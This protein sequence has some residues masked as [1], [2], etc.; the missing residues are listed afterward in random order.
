MA[1]NFKFVFRVIIFVFLFLVVVK[2]IATTNNLS[3]FK[4]GKECVTNKDC[5]KILRKINDVK[6]NCLNGYCRYENKM[7]WWVK[8]PP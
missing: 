6:R 5:H 7:G 3:A 1:E 4:P 2:G 8:S